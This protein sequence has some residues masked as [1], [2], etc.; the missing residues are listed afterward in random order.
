M[1]H[2]NELF[3]SLT[4]DSK[5]MFKYI[6]Y[7]YKAVKPQLCSINVLYGQGCDIDIDVSTVGTAHV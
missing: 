4:V 6:K 1:S 2:T 7:M 3:S 5:L